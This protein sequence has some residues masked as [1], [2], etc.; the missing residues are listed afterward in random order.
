MELENVVNDIRAII[1][2]MIEK[3]DNEAAEATNAFCNTSAKISN[4][5]AYAI[6][7][8]EKELNKMLQNKYGL[9]IYKV[10]E[11]KINK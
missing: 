8:L 3:Y 7:E 4:A 11:V 5:K 9:P 1:S 6:I 2:D 10:I